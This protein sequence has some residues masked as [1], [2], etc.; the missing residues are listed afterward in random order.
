MN[1]DT[2]DFSWRDTDSVVVRQQD[3]IAVYS[4]PDGDLVIRRRRSWDEEDDVWIVVAQ[5][6]IRT[7][8]NAMEKVLKEVQTAR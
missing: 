3:A 1:D 8:I 6:Q 5:T 2:E 4:N 7:V